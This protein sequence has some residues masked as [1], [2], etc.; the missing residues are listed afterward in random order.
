MASQKRSVTL[1][2]ETVRFIER[3][4]RDIGAE[5]M[6]WSAAINY[7]ISQLVGNHDANVMN[8]QK[9]KELDALMR[10][11]LPDLSEADW[12]EI[13]KV[14]NGVCIDLKPPHRLAS[15]MMD[16]YGAISIEQLT[17]AQADLVKRLHAM[18][19][20]QQTAILWACRESIF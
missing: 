8:A 4:S 1:T 15:Y 16:F 7:A 6:K 18:T 20:V 13:R 17:P 14:H 19:Q 5:D 12:Q 3:Y 10:M 11:S 9:A 2:D